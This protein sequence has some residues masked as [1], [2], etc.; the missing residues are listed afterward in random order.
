M[1]N[2]DKASATC[3]GNYE[4]QY[5]LCQNSGTSWDLTSGEARLEEE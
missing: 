3:G 2:T 4:E 1:W 5:I